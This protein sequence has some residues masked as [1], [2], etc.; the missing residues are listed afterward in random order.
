MKLERFIPEKDC[1]GIHFFPTI[2]YSYDSHGK[3]F[4]FGWLI[5]IWIFWLTK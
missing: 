5:W 2:G 1:K 3:A 4:W